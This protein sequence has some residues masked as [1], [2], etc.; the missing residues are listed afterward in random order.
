[1]LVQIERKLQLCSHPVRAGDEKTVT[2]RDHAR[3]TAYAWIK[4]LYPLHELVASLDINPGSLVAQAL[5]GPH[6]VTRRDTRSPGAG[7][8]FRPDRRRCR[9]PH[10]T[11][12][13]REYGDV[14]CSRAGVGNA[15]SMHSILKGTGATTSCVVS[16]CCYG[17]FLIF[18]YNDNNKV[19]F[20][21]M[22]RCIRLP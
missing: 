8:Q 5:L 4:L 9:D 3:K 11:Y 15:A 16:R 12:A 14:G 20:V 13:L 7:A 2:E 17:A 19:A 22:M 6:D 1:M 21:D 18:L 10:V